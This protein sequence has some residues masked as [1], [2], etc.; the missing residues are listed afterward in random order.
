MIYYGIA[1]AHGLESFRPSS[2]DLEVGGF[3]IDPREL[4]MMILRAQANSQRHAVVYQAKIGLPDAREIQGLL[5]EGKFPEALLELKARAKEVK[6][7]RLGG[8]DAE[9]AWHK[10]PNSDLDPFH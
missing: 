7:A 6:L 9:K 5:D 2:I 3:N 10:I 8:F 4:S 1:D